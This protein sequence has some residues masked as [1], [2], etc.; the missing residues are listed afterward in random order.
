MLDSRCLEVRFGQAAVEATIAEGDER[1]NIVI[2]CGGSQVSRPPQ[3]I[4]PQQRVRRPKVGFVD[5]DD[6]DV[7]RPL[8]N[9]WHEVLGVIDDKLD[10]G[11]R[12]RAFEAAEYGGHAGGVDFFV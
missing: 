7:E 3:L 5:L 11:A 2:S 6:H 1:D 4:T 9:P 8:I 10:R 12:V